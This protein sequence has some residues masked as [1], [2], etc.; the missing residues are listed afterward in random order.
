MSGQSATHARAQAKKA[1]LKAKD[2]ARKAA[3]KAKA[4]LKA[5][6]AVKRA[7]SAFAFFVADAFAAAKVGRRRRHVCHVPQKFRLLSNARARRPRWRTARR[8]RRS[9]RRWPASGKR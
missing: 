8:R 4:E 6:Y 3:A 9:W 2:E 7:R 1:A 5:R